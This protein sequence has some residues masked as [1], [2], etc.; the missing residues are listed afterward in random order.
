MPEGK[1][2]RLRD[3]ETDE[4]L[5]WPDEDAAARRAAERE[6][7]RQTLRAEQERQ[8]REAAEQRVHAL[9][10]ELARLRRGGDPEV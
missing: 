1:R 4:P 6:A 8:A 7:E 3:G 5:P 10:A 2:L 9:E